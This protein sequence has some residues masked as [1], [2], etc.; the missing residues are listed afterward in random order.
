LAEGLRSFARGYTLWLHQ[1]ESEAANL[2]PRFRQ[3]SEN[4]LTRISAAQDR[5]EAGICLLE[6]GGSI[7]T[8]FRL[9]NAAMREQMR[10]N[11]CNAAE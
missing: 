3:T 6:S 10:R 5:I 1:Q 8:A 4:L 11:A 9:A 7:L 2:S